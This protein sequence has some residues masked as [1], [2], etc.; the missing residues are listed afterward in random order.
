MFVRD[1]NYFA[2][3]VPCMPFGHFEGRLSEVKANIRHQDR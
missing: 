2:M 3:G 1:A